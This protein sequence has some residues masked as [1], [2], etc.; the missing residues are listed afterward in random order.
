MRDEVQRPG[1]PAAE[2]SGENRVIGVLLVDDEHPLDARAARENLRV[3]DALVLAD[4]S[5][6]DR[7]HRRARALARED[8]PVVLFPLVH[9]PSTVGELVPELLFDCARLLGCELLVL[10]PSPQTLL[11][12]DLRDRLRGSG[13]AAEPDREAEGR[14][15]IVVLPGDPDVLEGELMRP[16][17]RELVA[18][19]GP[20]NSPL[21]GRLRCRRLPPAEDEDEREGAPR[22]LPRMVLPDISRVR[23]RENE[24]AVPAGTLDVDFHQS[25]LYFDAAPFVDLA[26][27]C[28][29]SSALDIGCGLGVYLWLLGS[30]G[31]NRVVGVDG[32]GT[33]RHFLAADQYRA[34]DLATP[35]NL[36][37]EFDLVVCVEVVEHLAAAHESTLLESVARHARDTI[38]FSAARPGQPG[39]DHVNCREV[40]YW[41]ERWRELG[42][43]PDPF[44]SLRFRTL[45]TFFWFRRNVLV[46][47]PASEVPGPVHGFTE[48]DL[49]NLENRRVTWF[50][51]ASGPRFYPLAD[52]L[53]PL[54]PAG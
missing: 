43:R 49:E 52:P 37:E 5:R 33:S 44:A 38:V 9:H 17:L 51:Q 23:Q 42:W 54:E 27:T 41:I 32:F 6:L 45:S 26:E 2:R 11:G 12:A 7:S 53:P 36:G 30:L 31:A 19:S 22:E 47:R 39:N 20:P 40:S 8:L 14:D 29:P 18:P 15:E 46:L 1:R 25:S 21:L 48:A 3:L 4:R 10:V 50:A 24:R 28:L 16:L 34:H 13:S 35:L